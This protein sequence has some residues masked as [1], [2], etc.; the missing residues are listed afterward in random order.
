MAMKKEIIA[1]VEQKK[2][3]RVE[4]GLQHFPARE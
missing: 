2:R 3:P 4:L 1:W